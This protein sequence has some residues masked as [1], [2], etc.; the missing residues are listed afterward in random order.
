LQLFKNLWLDR[1]GKRLRQLRLF[2]E[3]QCER[4]AQGNLNHRVRSG[5]SEEVG[6]DKKSMDEGIDSENTT[7]KAKRQSVEAAARVKEVAG[8]AANEALRVAEA[9]WY[10]V[11]IKTSDLESTCELYIRDKPGQSL[12]LALGIGFLIGLLT[13]R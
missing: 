8:A 4:L 2:K 9:A 7:E 5:L 10:D 6:Y 13:R 11:K 1:H 3:P 12:L